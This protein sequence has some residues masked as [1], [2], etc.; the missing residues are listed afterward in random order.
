M[1]SVLFVNAR[2]SPLEVNAAAL[3]AHRLGFEVVLLADREPLFASELLAETRVVDTFDAPATRTAA[4]DLARRHDIQGVLTWG[5]RDVEF[6]AALAAEL[7]LPGLPTD[8]A[9]TVR[10]KYLTREA[11]AA[12]GRPDLMPGYARVHDEASLRSA[13]ERLGYP[14]ILKPTSAS[15]SRGIHRVDS[16]AGLTDEYGLLRSFT[17]PE[18][19]PIFRARPGELIYEEFLDGSEHSVEGLVVGDRLRIVGIT[20]KWV[21]PDYSIEYLQVHPTALDPVRRQAVEELTEVTV[22]ATGMRDCAFHLECRVLPDGSTKL[23]EVA[24]RIGGGYITSHLV[25]LATGIDFY[26]ATVAVATGNAPDLT[27]RAAFHAG[28]RQLISPASGVFSGFGGLDA[29]LELPG[30]EHVAL[31]Q[32]IGTKVALPPT[33]YMSCVLG[34]VIARRGSHTAVREVLGRAADVADPLLAEPAG[35][36]AGPR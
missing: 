14:A 8:A 10:N 32:A 3:A 29:V 2:R 12:A 34:S 36:S 9:R 30:V 4:L 11:L 21:T 31:D 13:A 6:V 20:D 26:A 5:D 16:A 35:S 22:R 1:P 23:L 7:G 27:P 18:R 19:D 28:S 24:G 17:R 25:P 33:D 15:G